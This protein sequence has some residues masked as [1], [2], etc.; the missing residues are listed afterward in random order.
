[1]RYKKFLAKLYKIGYRLLQGSGLSKYQNVRRIHRF[2]THQFKSDFIEF[3]GFQM[4]LSK[5]DEEGFSGGFSYDD[6]YFNLLKTEITSGENVIDIGAKIGVFSLAFSKFVGPTGTVF[7]FE[8]TPDSF[9][10][11]KMNKSVNNLKNII[12]EKKAIT[13]ESGVATLEIFE[14]SGSNRLNSNCEN[15]ISVDCISLDDYFL[16]NHKKISFIKI[17]VEGLEPRVL[18]G[19]KNILKE[20][21]KLKI[22]FEY[23][24]K[25]LKFFGYIPEKILE[26]LTK[27]G[28]SFFDLERDHNEEQ[29]V[30]HFVKLYNNTQKLTNILAKRG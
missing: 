14:A 28:F 17:D 5:D 19:M 22:L 21:I 1:M 6:E 3:Y 4:Y 10:I 16:D 11:L 29:N 9:E 13:D 27:Q 26:D 12:I 25:L 20:S 18:K 15:G 7:S 30:E 2:F 8:P 23:N 24:P